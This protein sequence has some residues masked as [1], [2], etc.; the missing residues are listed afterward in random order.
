MA[1]RLVTEDIDIL[2]I[3][4][5]DPEHEN[6]IQPDRRLVE[7]QRFDSNVVHLQQPS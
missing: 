5:A 2:V 3:P 1:E 4:M 6:K 7:S